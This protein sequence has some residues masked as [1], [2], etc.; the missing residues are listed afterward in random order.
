MILTAL[1]SELAG[2]KRTA[3]AVV[4]VSGLGLIAGCILFVNAAP[5]TERE[6]LTAIGALALGLFTGAGAAM[7]V[8]VAA[9]REA[10]AKDVRRAMG[11]RN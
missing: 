11:D 9:F 7:M 8:S 10:V 2:M 5:V 1:H 3:T 4:A 6:V